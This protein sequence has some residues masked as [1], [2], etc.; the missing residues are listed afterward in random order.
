MIVRVGVAQAEVAA[1]LTTGLDETARLVDEA[2]ASGVALLVFPETWLPGYPAWL[3]VC[4]DAAL[5]DHAPVKA[6]YRRMAE[7]SVGHDVVAHLVHGDAG[8][9]QTQGLA[10]VGEIG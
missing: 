5:W 4:R 6:V 2:R 7:Q 8:H 1:D 9:I 3:D 10:T